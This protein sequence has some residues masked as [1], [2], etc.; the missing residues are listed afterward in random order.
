MSNN[1]PETKK[2]YN[3][4]V[5]AAASTTAV[6]KSLHQI[7]AVCSNKPKK[8]WKQFPAL[9]WNKKMIRG[10]KC[11]H[12]FEMKTMQ[13]FAIQMRD[14]ASTTNGR[15]GGR[16][17]TRAVND[18]FIKFFRFFFYLFIFFDFSIFKLFDHSFPPADAPQPPRC[19]I[20]L[21]FPRSNDWLRSEPKTRRGGFTC[22]KKRRKRKEAELERLDSFFFFQIWNSVIQTTRAHCIDN[23][24]NMY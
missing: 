2:K 19:P 10:Q 13:F 11:R 5:A 6:Q 23:P 15:H 24:A 17:N 4:V 18:W 14:G 21:N 12:I 16:G 3:Y 22:G 9:N 1:I 20:L 7:V 8:R